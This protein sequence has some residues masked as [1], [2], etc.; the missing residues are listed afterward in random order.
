MVF[1]SLVIFAAEY[2]APPM[3]K[4][5][6]SIPNNVAGY[7]IP[8]STGEIENQIGLDIEDHVKGISFLKEFIPE[9][10]KMNKFS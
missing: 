2:F 7:Y 10:D 1:I 6:N 9:F 3:E 4:M 8:Q 5:D